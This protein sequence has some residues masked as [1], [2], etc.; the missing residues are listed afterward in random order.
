VDLL[1]DAFLRLGTGNATLTVYGPGVQDR[2]YM[3][4]LRKAADGAKGISFRDP[5]PPTSLAERLSGFDVLV[6]PS[7]W[8]ENSP[9]VLLYGLATRTPV[10]VTD[11]EGMNEFV[12][13][14]ENG[15]TFR[16]NDRDHLT[17]V[18]R[19][20]T[21]DPRWVEI[22][23]RNASYRKDVEDHAREVAAVYESVLRGGMS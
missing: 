13:Y 2:P 18:L 21:D 11:V 6:I 20:F 16:K 9:L 1:V 22:L 7:R 10:V 3:D 8:Y 19:K 15:F 17:A 12:R 5:F 14:G 4:A 23:S